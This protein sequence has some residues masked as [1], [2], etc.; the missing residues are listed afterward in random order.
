MALV[1][2]RLRAIVFGICV[3]IV[4]GAI[5]LAAASAP[6]KAL[7]PLILGGSARVQVP[8]GVRQVVLEKRQMTGWKPLAVRHLQANA[9]A[10]SRSVRFALPTGLT[11]ADIRVLAYHSAK[12]PTRTVTAA[13]SFQRTSVVSAVAAERLYSLWQG[14]LAQDDG[15]AQ[16]LPA[17]E[18]D[19]WK[20]AGN[21]LFFFNQ[22]RGL[23][24]LDLSDPAAPVRT[25][26]LR[27]AASGEQIYALNADG[28]SLALLGRSNTSTRAG[29]ASLFLL[30][31]ALGVPTL[32][33]EVPLEGEVIDSRLIG[34]R[35]YILSTRSLEQ[36]G[37]W[38]QEAVLQAVDLTTP[39]APRTL[40]ALRLPGTASA[41]QAAAG[42]L[43]V[44]TSVYGREAGTAPT[45]LHLID[46]ADTDGAPA[47][48]KSLV[49]VGPVADKFKIGIV[50]GAVVAT[51]LRWNQGHQETW[52]ETFPVAGADTAPLAQ[53]ELV[54]ARGEQLHATRY[55]GDRLYVVTFRNTDPLFVVDLADPAAPQ[56]AG[57][58]EIP[59]W[60]SYI[61]PLGDRLLTV[62]VASG[63]VTVSLFDV[64]D[65][66][67]PTLLSRLPLGDEGT[68]SWSE[69]N[70]DEKAVEYF[71]AAGIVLVP[72]QNYT[73]DGQVKAVAAIQVAR[74][75]VTAEAIIPHAFD[76]R[77][78]AVIGDYY[79]SISG[80]ELL[81][82]GRGP[83]GTGQPEVQVSLAWTTDRVVPLGDY[84]VQVEDGGSGDW[85]G[86]LV[87]LAQ[88]AGVN[89]EAHS[90]LR[91]SRAA[92]PDDLLGE[93]DLGVGRV[94]GVTAGNGRLYAAQL[95]SATADTPAQLRTWVFNLATAPDLA[96][97]TTLVHPL[98]DLSEWDLDLASG[99]LLWTDLGTLVWYAPARRVWNGGWWGGPV[100]VAESIPVLVD[101][102][103]VT[104][105]AADA[106]LVTQQT[107]AGVLC[108]IHGVDHDP[109]A[110]PVVRI[111]AGGAFRSA[112]TALAANGFLFFSFDTATPIP[113]KVPT[114]PTAVQAS[115][116]LM[117][118]WLPRPEA[119]HSWLQVVDLRE[120]AALVRDPVSIP[121]ALLSVAQ[122]DAQGAVLITNSERI[123]TSQ[124]RVNR[125]LEASAY[126]GVAAYLLHRFA[127]ATP[128]GA[129]S[130]SDGTYV[131]LADAASRPGVI[132]V[133]Y[134]PQTGLL[135]QIARWTTATPD[136]LH[137]V[138][139]Y[140]L[141]ATSGALSVARTSIAGRLTGLGT[142]QTSTNLSLRLDAAGIIPGQG[143]WVPAGAY[144]VEFLPWVDLTLPSASGR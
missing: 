50:K 76:P 53:M 33:A 24:V 12:F 13:R 59:G 38:T 2:S 96:H 93:L 87:R 104:S 143:I 57:T 85:F 137:A 40:T 135:A 61:E 9:S 11:A 99:R 17:V 25:G 70:Y 119:V 3:L 118:P 139:G 121:G 124:D 120:G 79:V 67:A 98:T 91:V 128:Y 90:M 16:D 140:L 89:G 114:N 133:G 8:A 83:N 39:A 115:S 80:Q 100:R 78:G 44:G 97:I 51:T 28:S 116:L 113:A 62:G 110:G 112:S 23:Q 127:T 73:A 20:I 15:S 123:D 55:D 122:A 117:A 111:Q 49:L 31:V 126:D 45:R 65:A 106:A 102:T 71:P 22:Y 54:A 82:L 14:A 4:L 43:L 19:I 48:R 34:N 29:A 60:S 77:R 109:T 95:V 36:D 88:D 86:P 108:I 92:A 129:A 72:F 132:S 37:T 103:P 68:W 63:R 18:S 41:L 30:R 6:A 134:D 58:L 5:P 81:V 136:T 52:V 10:S 141:A 107:L 138:K 35:L 84:L 32:V 69:A 131:Y 56:L 64:A 26:T 101:P 130:T 142:N 42:Y 27:L 144:G 75:A 21:Q 125:N 66:A 1:D 94:V 74:D 7:T 47:L 46:L 105:A